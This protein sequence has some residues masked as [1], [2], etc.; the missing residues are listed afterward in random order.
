MKMKFVSE[1]RRRDSTSKQK[2]PRSRN[3]PSAIWL[4]VL[5]MEIRK[6]IH[7]Y[8]LIQTSTLDELHHIS[9]FSVFQTWL[10]SRWSQSLRWFTRAKASGMLSPSEQKSSKTASRRSSAQLHTAWDQRHK[11]E[12][13]LLRS[14]VILNF[15]WLNKKTKWI[16]KIKPCFLKFR[17]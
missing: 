7:I 13:Q 12:L 6:M 3:F 15:L 5:K 4:L 14:E 17:L 9:R 16:N 2:T 10:S 1:E 8:L 11:Q